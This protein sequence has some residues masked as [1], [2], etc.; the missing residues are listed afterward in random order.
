MK[1]II[2]NL[3]TKGAVQFHHDLLNFVLNQLRY[4]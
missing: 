2:F 3:I 1:D 4:R